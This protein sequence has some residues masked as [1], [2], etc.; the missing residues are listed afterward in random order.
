M[1]GTP[2]L[3]GV[4]A[5]WDDVVKLHETMRRQ[6]DDNWIALLAAVEAEAEPGIYRPI[7]LAREAG[8]SRALMSALVRGA[9]MDAM[10]QPVIFDFGKVIESPYA[11]RR[12]VMADIY[13]YCHDNS[14]TVPSRN[15]TYGTPANVGTPVG[16]GTI[17]R[18]TVDWN[19]Y[20]LEACRVETK[21]FRCISDQNN[22]GL[23]HGEV[24]QVYGE[25][26]SLDAL[27]LL[28]FG[29]GVLGTVAARHA[30]GGAGGS[31][32]RNS[33]FDALNA[34][35][36]PTAWDVTG[37]VQSSATYYRDF[38]GATAPVSCR[39][40]TGATL[41]QKIKNAARTLDSERPH[42]LRVMVNATT[43]TASGQLIIRMGAHSKTV[44]DVSALGAGWQEV[45][46][47]LNENCWFQNFNEDEM[48]ISIEWSGTNDLLVD[49]LIFTA[50][51]VIDGTFWLPIGGTT[52]WM[53]DDK[54]SVA[55]TGGDPAVNG[56][57]RNYWTYL[58]GLGYFPHDNGAATAT[59]ADPTI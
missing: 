30:G 19:A 54:I 17:R 20:E 27:K 59:W 25:Q 42:A 11:D 57:I 16:N 22:G 38:P 45:I 7:G 47:D 39:M 48:D 24:F 34:T 18:L 55:D 32:C 46:V 1:S 12:A 49:D 56:G 35:G 28:V 13:E 9:R 58:A 29:S 37:T 26:L 43:H 50:L 40:S 8:Q 5:A 33:S 15:I 21:T 51:D 10:L 41:S 36:E 44:A 31:L 14:I 4:Q 6:I 2:T 52:P 3:V 23:R 53:A